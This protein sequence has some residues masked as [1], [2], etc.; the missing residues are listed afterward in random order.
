MITVDE[1]KVLFGVRE[2]QELGP[3]FGRGKGAVSAW[4]RKGVPASIEIK[5]RELLAREGKTIPMTVAEDDVKYV[6]RAAGEGLLD[7][8][9]EIMKNWPKSKLLKEMG[10]WVEEIETQKKG[11]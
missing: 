2:D 7:E 11:S 6:E 8:A 4:R 5:A 9:L 1:L 10:R 3:F